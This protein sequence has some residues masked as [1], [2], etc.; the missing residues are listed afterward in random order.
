LEGR[1]NNLPVDGIFLR[2]TINLDKFIANR[3]PIHIN[4]LFL[5]IYEFLCPDFPSS[6]NMM[7]WIAVHRVCA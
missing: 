4:L 1:P 3:M 7:P 2:L 5:G 6:N